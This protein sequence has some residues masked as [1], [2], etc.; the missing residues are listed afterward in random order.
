MLS[1]SDRHTVCSRGC[2]RQDNKS[3]AQAPSR[4]RGDIRLAFEH[5]RSP[6]VTP[7][8]P[9]G[10]SPDSCICLLGPLRPNKIDNG[11]PLSH[12]PVIHQ[13]GPS[14]SVAQLGA[15]G[16]APAPVGVGPPCDLRCSSDPRRTPPPP[17]AHRRM[18]ARPLAV[19]ARLRPGTER[20]SVV[21]GAP[22]RAS[23]VALEAERVPPP[24]RRR[25]P[26][27]AQLSRPAF[28][29]TLVEEVAAAIPVPPPAF[30]HRLDAPCRSLLLRTPR[31]SRRGSLPLAPHPHHR[32]QQPW[33]LL[34]PLSRPRPRC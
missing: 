11:V 1:G 32:T 16:R 3:T 27:G 12:G 14:P 13:P 31:R 21:T 24:C 17:H 34:A 4:S 9:F 2:N 18:G 20:G 33:R 25:T 8:G 22:R 19:S 28:R 23:R 10:V 7:A 30:P 29:V 26:A 6:G 15:G 5:E